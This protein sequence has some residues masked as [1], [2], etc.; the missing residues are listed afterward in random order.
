MKINVR[1][2]GCKGVDWIHLA[3]DRD[4]LWAFVNMEIDFHLLY[5]VGKFSTVL[6]TSSFS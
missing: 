5:D 6:R 1:E 3:W 2:T 4:N